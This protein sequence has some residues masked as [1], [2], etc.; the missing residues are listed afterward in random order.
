MPVSFT[1]T[2]QVWLSYTRRW[3]GIKCVYIHMH[4]PMICYL[5]GLTL[6]NYPCFCFTRH[7]IDAEL[8]YMSVGT[9]DDNHYFS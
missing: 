7:D 6:D 2:G 9:V 5:L 1:N 4:S 8:G 3:A